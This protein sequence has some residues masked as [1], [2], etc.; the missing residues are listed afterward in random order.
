MNLRYCGILMAL[1]CLLLGGCVPQ[2]VAVGPAAAV[3]RLRTGAPLL[4][5]REACLGK[6]QQVQQQA[7]QLAAAR[8]WAELAALVEGV[9]YQDDLT[10]YYIG[11][12]AEASGYP[13]AAASYYRQSTYLTGTAIGC[14]YLSRN[15]GGYVFPR[16]AL[17]RLAAIERSLAYRPRPRRIAP[18]RGPGTPEPAEVETVPNAPQAVAPTPATVQSPPPAEI[19]PPPPPAPGR[20]PGSE[21]IE[22]PPAMR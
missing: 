12:A 6:W 22:P 18:P 17:V 9:G 5:C 19:A 2:P 15:C 14:Q 21:Y 13:G 11:E 4:G 7:A 16:A 8:R 1:G 3:E 10:L 20:P